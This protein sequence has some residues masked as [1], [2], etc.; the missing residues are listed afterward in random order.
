M[1]TPARF[2]TVLVVG[3][4]LGAVLFAVLD[5][6][7]L[8]GAPSTT[9]PVAA[10]TTSTSTTTTLSLT[11]T[12]PPT[13]T[14][15]LPPKGRL[16]IHGTGD[17]AV[18]PDYIPALA[19]NGWDYAWSGVDGLFLADDLTIVNLECVP[20]DIGDPEPKEFV[21]RCPTE[22]LPSLPANGVDVA[23]MGNNHSGDFGKEALVDGRANLIAAGLGAVGAG[24]DYNEAG[25]P[26]VYE[27][28]GWTI[29]VVGFGGVAPTEEWY[30]TPD[31]AGMRSG[32]HIDQMVEAVRAADE[33]ADL[34]VVTIHWGVELDT[35]PRA[36]D[37]ERAQAMI[38]AGADIIFGHHPHR[39]Q[40]LEFIDGKPV[41]WSLGNFV[42]P[43]NST[44]SAT[45]AIARAVVRPNGTIGA[46]LIPAF[47]ESHGHPVITG[48][49]TCGP[50]VED[51]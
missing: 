7:A 16:I 30:A 15:T 50:A 2:L 38:D 28:N 13:T 51:G 34:V 49:A 8:G 31:R 29:A 25:L 48:E 6:D 24:K 35:T 14:T 20:S 40:P 18:D 17:V 12:V 26:A 11:T 46:C 5:V 27:V 9:E 44:E 1:S 45:T 47:I 32:D 19:A 36:D 10:A 41:F 43:H 42:W 39:L 4:V 23:N 3:V 21:F 22:A 37:R 33:I